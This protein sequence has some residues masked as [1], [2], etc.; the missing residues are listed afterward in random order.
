MRTC[1]LFSIFLLG[2]AGIVTGLHGCNTYDTSLLVDDATDRPPAKNGIGWWS[3]PDSRGCFSA[4]APRPE[5]RPAPGS[6]KDVGAIVL[7]ISSMRLG[8]LNEQGGVDP[9]AWQDIGLD[10]DGV[11]TASETCTSEDPPPSCKAGASQLPRDGKYCRDNTFG[12]LEYSAALVPQLAKQYGLSDDA[13]NCALCV[14]HYTFII[15]VTGYNG[16]PNDDRVRIDL[17][18]SPGLEKPLPWDCSQPSWVTQPCFTPDMPWTLQE[19]T[20][21]EKRGGPDLPDSKIFSADAYVRENYL[22]TQLP[23]DTLFWFPGYKGLVVA[24][25]I[26]LQKGIVVGKLLKGQDNV[27]RIE[28][29][30]IAGRARQQDVIKGFRLIGFCETNDK[31][32]YELTSTFVNDNLDVLADGRNDPNVPCDVMSMGVTFNARQAKAG[33]TEAVAPLVE[34]VV[35]RTGPDTDA[36][37]TDAGVSDGG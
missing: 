5:D 20:L 9:N 17:Y 2:A 8:S 12:K 27:W 18:P 1:G 36:G 25:P 7:A 14:G 11:C 33:R 24:Y 3:K 13:F 22:V 23:E 15:R 30:V 26:R 4:G 6:D 10:L 31:D 37:T 21:L 29:G 28:D 19:D 34:C 32:N 35:P 16:E